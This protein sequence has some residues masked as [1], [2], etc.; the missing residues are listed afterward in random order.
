[1]RHKLYTRR[2]GSY[3]L[4]LTPRA[5]RSSHPGGMALWSGETEPF[6]GP[7]SLRDALISL[8]G[9]GIAFLFWL[10]WIGSM[11]VAVCRRWL[12]TAAL[13]FLL[14]AVPGLLLSWMVVFGYLGDRESWAASA[15]L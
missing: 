11:L 15:P 14:L 2:A 5:L 3:P 9:G 1:M 7:F 8:V 13:A 6:F 10:G 4:C 12:P